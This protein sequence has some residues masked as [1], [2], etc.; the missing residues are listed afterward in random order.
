V[1]AGRQDGSWEE[2]PPRLEVLTRV[3]KCDELLTSSTGTAR[4]SKRAAVARLQNRRVKG[5]IDDE[6]RKRG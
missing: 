2:G 5:I 3:E 6:E 1:E 4:T